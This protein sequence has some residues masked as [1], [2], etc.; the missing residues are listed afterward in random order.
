MSPA[1]EHILYQKDRRAWARYVA[2]RRAEMLSAAP[3]EK[4]KR[5]LWR[6]FGEESRRAIRELKESA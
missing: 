3:D 1:D 2:K 6:A 4:A 5:E